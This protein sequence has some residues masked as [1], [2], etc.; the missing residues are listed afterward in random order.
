[1]VPSPGHGEGCNGWMK[2]VKAGCE[3]GA[4]HWEGQG[5]W[6]PLHGEVFHQ[7]LGVALIPVGLVPS[8]KE[9]AQSCFLGC[10]RSL[11]QVGNG[12][13]CTS[14]TRRTR[15]KSILLTPHLN[16]RD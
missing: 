14:D 2:A 7:G 5:L 9:G 16:L 1:M 12:S 6:V 15:W 10:W 3:M 13:P 4:V 8:C 11:V